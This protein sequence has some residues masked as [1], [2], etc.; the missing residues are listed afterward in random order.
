MASYEFTLPDV[1]EGLSQGEIVQW[2]V[3]VGDQ[4]VADQHLVDVQTDKAIVEIPSPVT[5]TVTQLGGGAGD[6]LA[7]GAVLAVFETDGAPGPATTKAPEISPSP[8]ATIAPASPDPPA[9]SGSATGRVRASPA[10]RK[11]AR[12]LGVELASI[13]PS[14]ERGQITRSDV[15]LAVGAAASDRPARPGVAATRPPP[16]A[17]APEPAHEDRVEP[18][19]GLRRQ[20]AQTMEAAWRDVPHIFSMKEVDARGLVDARR[21]LNEEFAGEGSPLS[22]LP[23]FVSACVAA[24]QAHPRFNAS[25]DMGSEQIIYRHRYNV[26]I[27]TATPDGLMVVVV[28]DADRK[29]LWELGAEIDQLAM[30]ARARKISPAQIAQGTFTV[31]N[32]GSYGGWLGAPIIRP[33]EVAIAGFGRIRDA[34]VPIDGERQ[35]GVAPL[36]PLCV[37]TDHRLNDGDHLGAF[38]DTMETYLREPIRLLSRG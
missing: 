36:L 37:S 23:F 2:K 19:R 22:Y 17:G 25:L 26:G 20:I 21:S 8:T 7:V 3:A 28:H 10:V 32:Y 4:V 16:T 34:V 12:S 9:Q 13:T 18:L 6:I 15:E 38:M 30:Q 24:L 35:V 1:G 29:S 5:G 31:S 33:P 11:L 14:G 27:A